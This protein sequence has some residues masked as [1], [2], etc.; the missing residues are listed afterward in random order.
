[1]DVPNVLVSILPVELIC[2]IT[3]YNSRVIHNF[4]QLSVTENKH[5]YIMFSCIDKNIIYTFLRDSSTLLQKKLNNI[6]KYRIIYSSDMMCVYKNKIYV[7]SGEYVYIF[8]E[9]CV[10]INT[11][12]LDPAHYV[13][14]LH[15]PCIKVT[16]NTI[17]ICKYKGSCVLILDE[18]KNVKITNS[19]SRII[20]LM[21]V[22]DDTIYILTNEEILYTCSPDG[23][24]TIVYDFKNIYPSIQ[25]INFCIIDGEIY[26]T[27]LDASIVYMLDE[28]KL[29][30]KMLFEKDRMELAYHDDILYV[31]TYNH[32][33]THTV[34]REIVPIKIIM[35]GVQEQLKKNSIKDV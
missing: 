20:F 2:I 30:E 6:D 23:V 13:V 12:Q 14:P 1:M 11:I 15:S 32:T 35:K 3:E 16:A 33:Y 27:L 18:N 4:Q 28:H 9:H 19:L 22:Y 8:D 26:L 24:L 21:K 34:K 5:K 29:V 25:I 10:K 31:Y 7:L 17:F